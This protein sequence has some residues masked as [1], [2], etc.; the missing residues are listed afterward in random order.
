TFAG[1]VIQNGT[2]T[3][4]GTA[5]VAQS[6]TVS[7]VLAGGQG[8]VK[9]G[10]GA[11][12]LSGVN[13]YTGGTTVTVGSLLLSGGNERLSTSGAI[14][15]S[16]GVLDLGGNIQTTLGTV[17]FAGGVIQNGTLTATG[18]AYVAQSGTL[19]AI[20]AGTQALVKDG[21]GALT[22][23][24]VNSYN[25]GTTVNNG[26]L[27]LGNGHLCG[28]RSSKRDL[29]LDGDGVCGPKR[30]GERDPRWDAESGEERLW[31]A[32]FERS[33]LVL[34]WDDGERW[35]VATFRWR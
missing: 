28:R 18:T 4:T 15:T 8:L 14:T 17:T 34:R 20:L 33:E 24:G 32:D 1:G 35:F 30:H 27:L 5:F 29:Y 7:A 10:G 21:A 19:S 22:L 31:G 11:L 12:T 26:S 16:G 23:S 2:L 3:A 25:G 9:S 6:G 13:S